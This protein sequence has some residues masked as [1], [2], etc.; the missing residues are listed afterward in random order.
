VVRIRGHDGRAAG[1]LLVASPEPR[2]LDRPRLAAL[3][4]LAAQ[5]GTLIELTGTRAQLA[6]A[7][8]QVNQSL[9]GL[10]HATERIRSMLASSLDAVVAIDTSGRIT[11]FNPAAEA[12]FGFSADRAIGEQMADLII[13]HALRDAHREG[14]RRHLETGAS[15]VLGRRI[16]IEA[17][18]SD[19]SVFPVE[20]TISPIGGGV[21]PGFTAYLRDIS[22]QKRAW[23][24]AE[25]DLRAKADFLARLSHDIR[26][27]LNGII[28]LTDLGITAEAGE[29]RDEF[30]RMTRDCAY[31]LMETV[32]SILDYSKMDS[33]GIE[34]VLRSFTPQTA[35]A[36][37]LKMLAVR[38]RGKGLS[39]RIIHRSKHAGRLIGDPGLLRQIVFNLVSNAIRFTPNGHVK[40]TVDTSPRDRDHVKMTLTVEDSGIGIPLH[41]QQ[42]VFEPYAQVHD[43]APHPQTGTGLGLTIVK[44]LVDAMGGQIELES[45]AGAGT[46]FTVT[47]E[48]Q[49]EAQS[50]LD[51]PVKPTPERERRQLHVLVVDDNDTNRLV[52][53]RLL[54]R[55]GYRVT[56]VASGPE[57][58]AVTATTRPDL[59]LM[60]V[61]L[62]G[63]NGMEA[64]AAIRTQPGHENIPAI[65]LTAHA[66][67]GDRERFMTMGMEGYVSKP[68]ST[69]ALL[70][71]MERVLG[72]ARMRRIRGRSGQHEGQRFARLIDSLDG[73][74]SLFAIVARKAAEDFSAAAIDMPRWLRQC[75][76]DSLIEK[77]HKLKGSW[78]MYSTPEHVMLAERCLSAVTQR[79]SEAAREPVAT[80]AAAL[81]ETAHALTAWL[82]RNRESS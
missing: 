48:F 11:D 55:H 13:P 18:R 17:L 32:N 3:S 23:A 82:E 80:L 46:R 12:M 10:A 21:G 74:T 47:L 59:V 37:T 8:V 70:T 41:E 19:G 51:T 4:L 77:A 16:E 40:V 34:P 5:A 30:L 66:L 62:P 29:E 63:M 38:A 15:T 65:A 67:V 71:E 24:R 69:E 76:W 2:Q 58:L 22:E 20:L 31:G 42:R 35:L 9:Q 39:F 64:M 33:I 49:R 78:P 57:A 72:M 14:M 61:R 81:K 44:R 73:S 50:D 43:A 60:D 68:F 79:Q 53:G 45:E 1:A 25:A 36:E 75:D 26:T 6:E 52:A 27:P 28:G 54:A 7:K 56:E